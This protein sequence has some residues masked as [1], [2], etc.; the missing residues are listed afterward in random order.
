MWDEFFYELQIVLKF[1]PEKNP[2]FLWSLKGP[3]NY[4][5]GDRG[6]VTDGGTPAWAVERLCPYGRL[7]LARQQG[8]WESHRLSQDLQILNN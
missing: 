3:K 7:G 1:A 2:A 4:I 8:K 5:L 6:N